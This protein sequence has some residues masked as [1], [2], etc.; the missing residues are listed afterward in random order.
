MGKP[1]INKKVCMIGALSVGKT[2]LVQRFVHAIFSDQNLSSIGV[3]ISKKTLNADGVEVTLVLWDME[4][5]DDFAEENIAYLRGAMG[6]FMICDGT[7]KET[8]DTALQLRDLAL[9]QAGD[10]PHILLVNKA[11]LDWE[12]TGEQLEDVKKTGIPVIKTSAKTG[13]GLEKAFTALTRAM[14]DKDHQGDR[15]GGREF[16]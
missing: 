11:D 13:Q 10:I 9:E 8:L 7:R 14:L 1:V 3:K 16:S 12:I 15:E 5:K 4:G 2:A 6:F